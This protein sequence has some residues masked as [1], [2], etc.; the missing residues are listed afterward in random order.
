MNTLATQL[1]NRA[2]ALSG[3]YGTARTTPE[4][5]DAQA[6]A[7]LVV[8]LVNQELELFAHHCYKTNAQGRF[9]HI[10]A[11]GQL[12]SGNWCP[13]GSSGKSQLTRTQRD[14]VRRWLLLLE[15]NHLR[16]VWQYYPKTRRWYVNLH[17]YP[18]L[19]QALVWLSNHQLTAEEWLNLSV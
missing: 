15:Q 5:I 18:T 7:Q 2:A 19:D 13:W 11:D 1:V 14:T 10:L 16:P 6:L 9:L 4:R 17:R 3:A 12:C 8:E